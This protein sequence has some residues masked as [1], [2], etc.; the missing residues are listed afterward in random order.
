MSNDSTTIKPW[1]LCK[2]AD[3]RSIKRMLYFLREYCPQW[4]DRLTFADRGKIR[5]GDRPFGQVTW[6]ECD[7]PTFYFYDIDVSDVDHLSRMQRL[8]KNRLVRTERAK[9]IWTLQDA[10]E[11]PLSTLTDV[12]R[13]GQVTIE[14]ALDDLNVTYRCLWSAKLIDRIESDAGWDAQGRMVKIRTFFVSPEGQGILNWLDDIEYA[15]ACA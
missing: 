12:C 4:A 13:M 7:A 2:R 11:K 14:S 6:D 15:K 10:C 1:E 5:L 3:S 9:I 8:E